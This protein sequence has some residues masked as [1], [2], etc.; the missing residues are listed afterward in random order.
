L[1]SEGQQFFRLYFITEDLD[2]VRT[3]QLIIAV[4]QRPG[5]QPRAARAR[6][7]V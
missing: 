7:T 2:K 4:L 3:K 6:T 5:A 1:I